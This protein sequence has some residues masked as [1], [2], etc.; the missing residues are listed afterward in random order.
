MCCSNSDYNYRK[1]MDI[2]PWCSLFQSHKSDLQE[3]KYRIQDN[4]KFNFDILYIEDQII[5]LYNC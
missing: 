2:I 5:Y 4:Y 1:C 3:D